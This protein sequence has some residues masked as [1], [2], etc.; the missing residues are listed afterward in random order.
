LVTIGGRSTIVEDCAGALAGDSARV[1]SPGGVAGRHASKATP[2]QAARQMTIA[3]SINDPLG[4][5]LAAAPC[6]KAE[7]DI[8]APA[9]MA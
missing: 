3:N 2:A 5:S 1:S 9:R 4:D 8:S 6:G 7:F